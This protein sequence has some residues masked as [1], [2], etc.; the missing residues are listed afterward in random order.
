MPSKSIELKGF[1][2]LFEGVNGFGTWDRRWCFLNNYNI[3][4]WKYP[5]DEYRNGPLG[6]IN[7]TKCINEKVSI[8]PRDLCARKYSIELSICDSE[9]TLTCDD[10][11]NEKMKIK[12]YFDHLF[13]LLLK[14]E[15][16]YLFIFILN[17]YRLS[18]DTKDQLNDWLTNI[19]YA[20]ANLRL[21]NPK[22]VKPIK[23]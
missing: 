22:A 21:W 15:V 23:K 8:L 6:I 10:L 13:L 5:E 7:L 19:N 17:R 4:Y 11:N 20:L 1:M 16:F 14:T 3:S 18:A 2:T 12:R 9:T